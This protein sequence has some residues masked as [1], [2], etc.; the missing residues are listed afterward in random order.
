MELLR[1]AQ[2]DPCG[3]S[4][5]LQ[6]IKVARITSKNRAFVDFVAKKHSPLQS[7]SQKRVEQ[8]KKKAKDVVLLT[9]CKKHDII[10]LLR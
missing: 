8:Q 7:V 5:V 3:R 4:F 6:N 10:F 1:H 2:A 9:Y